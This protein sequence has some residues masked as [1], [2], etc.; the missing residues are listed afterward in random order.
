M[1]EIGLGRCHTD[2]G[3]KKLGRGARDEE[4]GV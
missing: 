2:K 4:L 1:G 3:L